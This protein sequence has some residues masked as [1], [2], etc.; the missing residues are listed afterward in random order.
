MLGVRS[1]NGQAGWIPSKGNSGSNE[2]VTTE[3]Q[4]TLRPSSSI[5]Y[6]EALPNKVAGKYVWLR[7]HMTLNAAWQFQYLYHDKKRLHSITS[8]VLQLSVQHG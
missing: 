2:H 6:E 4:R 3:I 7:V 8:I 1:H 5:P